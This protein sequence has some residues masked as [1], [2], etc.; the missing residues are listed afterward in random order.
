MF[1]ERKKTRLI[2]IKCGMTMVVSYL[3]ENI[4]LI[5]SISAPHT[6]GVDEVEV[7]MT[8]YVISFPR[9][10]QSVKCLVSGYPAVA[11]S[12]GRLRENFMY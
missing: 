5:H 10:L 11:H 4:A 1:R 3:K 2:C 9:V 6:R 7:V 12:A 8:N